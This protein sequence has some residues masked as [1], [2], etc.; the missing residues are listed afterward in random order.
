VQS[1]DRAPK[2]KTEKNM[3]EQ[4]VNFVAGKCEIRKLRN[5][6]LDPCQSEYTEECDA[7]ATETVIIPCGESGDQ[8]HPAH[9]FFGLCDGHWTWVRRHFRPAASWPDE[10]Y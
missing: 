8:N 9:R 2:P 7:D 4:A 6:D 10:S 3:G 5:F 1:V